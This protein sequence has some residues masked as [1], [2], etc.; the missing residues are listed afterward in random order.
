[1]C[2]A[3]FGVVEAPPWHWAL[4]LWGVAIGLGASVL[5]AGIGRHLA[6]RDDVS[7]ERRLRTHRRAVIYAAEWLLLGVLVGILSVVADS[8]WPDVLLLAA[9]VLVSLLVAAVVANV[10]RRQA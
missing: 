9:L 4:F 10:A 8:P 3:A 2:V 5:I 1:M 6:R 7:P